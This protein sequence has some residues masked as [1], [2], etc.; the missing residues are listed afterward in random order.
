MPFYNAPNLVHATIL[1]RRWPATTATA[2][3]SG[4]DGSRSIP[5]ASALH[6][7]LAPPSRAR[8]Q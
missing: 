3:P 8:P 4:R 5:R 2:T 1:G 7:G 6:R